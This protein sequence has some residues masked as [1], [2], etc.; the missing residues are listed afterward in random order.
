MKSARLLSLALLL[1]LSACEPKAPEKPDKPPTP[2]TVQPA[3][4]PDEDTD[5][6]P[7]LTSH[8]NAGGQRTQYRAYF[9]GPQLTE[10][11]ESSG[12][13]NDAVSEYHYHGARLLRYLQAAPAA[14]TT[15]IELD[16]QGRVQR[17]V[18]GSRELAATE[19]DAIRTHAQLLRSHALAQQA[20]RMHTQ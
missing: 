4:S 7:A 11:K 17:A 15:L 13:P 16:E 8:I 6:R 19:I 20:S 2:K 12:S 9:E 10:I 1:V 18:A 14:E 5:T 3:Q